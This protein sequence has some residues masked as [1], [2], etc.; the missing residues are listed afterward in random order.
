MALPPDDDRYDSDDSQVVH[1][2]AD[3]LDVLGAQGTGEKISRTLPST[4]L[5]VMALGMGALT[6]AARQVFNDPYP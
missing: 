2:D 1:E 5:V 6:S 4:G 3:E